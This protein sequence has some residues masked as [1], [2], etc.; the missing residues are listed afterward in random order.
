MATRVAGL[1]P[2]QEE[3]R[4]A[5]A[6]LLDLR[7]SL[8]ARLPVAGDRSLLGRLPADPAQAGRHLPSVGVS[9]GELR[10][11]RFLN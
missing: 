7:R 6:D 1:T 3:L 8:I 4:S 5:L 11:A 2:E 9:V 10:A